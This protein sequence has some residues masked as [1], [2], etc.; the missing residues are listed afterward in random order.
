MDKTYKANII[1][2]EANIITAV[3]TSKKNLKRKCKKFT[4]QKYMKIIAL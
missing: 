3:G 4:Q 1:Q 2:Y